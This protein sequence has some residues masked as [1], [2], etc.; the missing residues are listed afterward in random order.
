MRKEKY[1]LILD[2]FLYDAIILS[3][4]EM[5]NKLIS[6]ERYT[7]AVDEALIKFLNAKKK[8]IQISPYT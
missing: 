5:K 1:N 4:I 7:D 8:Y 6:E 2:D 3:L